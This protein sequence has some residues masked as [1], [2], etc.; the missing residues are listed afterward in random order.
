MVCNLARRPHRSHPAFAGAGRRQCSRTMPTRSFLRPPPRPRAQTRLHRPASLPGLTLFGA[1]GLTQKFARHSHDEYA[2]GV[3]TD[4]ALGFHYRGGSH[5][6]GAG[7]V[8]IV[9]PG[10][11]H[12]GEPA[13]GRHW[14]YRMFY[15]QP[16]LLQEA[17]RQAG[18]RDATLP[19][20]RAGVLR[21][22]ALAAAVLA[23][24]GDL[25]QDTVQPLEAQSR[26]LALLTTWLDR[27]AER[28]GAATRRQTMARHAKA[29]GQVR[30]FLEEHWLQRPTLEQLALLAGLSPFQLLRAFSREYG[31]PPHAWLVQRQLREARRLLA[32]GVPPAEAAAASGFADQS[33]L[34]RHF[35]RTWGFTPGQFRNFV[36]EG[37]AGRT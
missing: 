27:H 10:E 21:D 34:H 11:V 28:S 5:L 16:Q 12:T 20:F 15:L 36:Q 9:V 6:A 19:F 4:G 1:E 8:N 24:H 33:H 13:L 25:L 37:A 30:E 23:L 14:S 3:V 22:P 2:L 31:L 32:L 18:R 26:L 35:Q 7:E 29:V 17:A